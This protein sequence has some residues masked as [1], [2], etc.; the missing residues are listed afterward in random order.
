MMERS[1]TGNSIFGNVDGG[2]LGFPVNP[3]G[4]KQELR[5]LIAP[6]TLAH[7]ERR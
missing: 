6:K 5:R 1:V 4:L 7:F 3:C 2:G